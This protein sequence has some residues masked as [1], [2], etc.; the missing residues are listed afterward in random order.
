MFKPNEK[1]CSKEMKF[2]FTKIIDLFVD[3]VVVCSKVW[4]FFIIKCSVLYT[5]QRTVKEKY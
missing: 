1:V 4:Q 3:V 5:L 2:E